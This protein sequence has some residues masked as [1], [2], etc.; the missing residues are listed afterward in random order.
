MDTWLVVGVLLLL[1]L[2]IRAVLFPKFTKLSAAQRVAWARLCLAAARGGSIY[3]LHGLL[4]L[5]EASL[6]D[7]PVGCGTVRLRL[8]LRSELLDFLGAVHG[9]TIATAVDV[10]TTVAL[11]S[12]GL[13][14]GVSTSLG[15]TLFATHAP[16]AELDIVAT[17][18]K[19]GEC[20]TPAPTHASLSGT[21]ARR[22]L[23]APCTSSRPALALHP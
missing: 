21:I 23:P 18:L 11:V 19:S 15:V 22:E 3:D 12:V 17:V 10:S 9:G 4:T 7:A 20:S 13:F 14:P 2:T 8:R 16:G 5:D 1:L 6:E